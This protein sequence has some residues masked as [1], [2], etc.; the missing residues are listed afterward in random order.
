LERSILRED[1]GS[2]HR[3]MMVIRDDN[4]ENNDD[5]KR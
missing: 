2:D 5:M 4:E 3:E 1:P